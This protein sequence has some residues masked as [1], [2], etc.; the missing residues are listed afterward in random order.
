VR[1][2]VALTP[3][4]KVVDE[5]WSVTADLRAANPGLRWAR[6]EQWHLTCA[7]LGEVADAVRPDLEE[8]LG[9]AAARHPPLVLA[10]GEGGRF[11][12]RVLWTR[13]RGDADGLRRLADSVR[14]AARRCRLPVDERP[15]RPHLTLARA[16]DGAV[17]LRPAVADLGGFDGRT[18]TAGE[19][20]LV[21]SH[22][23]A[24]PGGSARHEPV[25]SWPLAGT[26]TRSTCPRNSPGRAPR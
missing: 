15:Y 23:G 13:V 17:D 26:R 14:A 22:L 7:F 8:R 12:N 18:W 3:P 25:R 9:R 20:H 5:L 2:F 10:L 16:R 24:G 1:L 19:L 11:G 4:A 21:R 6:P